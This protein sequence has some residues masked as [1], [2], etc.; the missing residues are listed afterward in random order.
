MVRALEHRKFIEDGKLHLQGRVR[1]AQIACFRDLENEEFWRVA[2]VEGICLK[3]SA[4]P[5]AAR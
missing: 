1:G 3:F 2:L 5:E 4:L